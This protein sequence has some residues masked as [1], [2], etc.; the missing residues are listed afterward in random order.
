RN[1]LAS[2]VGDD[3][4]ERR[5]DAYLETGPDVVSFLHENT[6]LRLR[7]VREY[8][9]YH[10]EAA[11]G[12]ARGR[13]IE[14]LPLDGRT[15]GPELTNLEPPYSDPPLGVPMNQVDYRWI[16]LLARHPKG[17]WQ[18]AKLGTRWLAGLAQGKRVQLSM[19][20]ALAGGL[21]AGLRRA[22]V[23][24]W[25]R[26]PIVDL[27]TENGRVT[28]VTVER[29]GKQQTIRAR[30]GVILGTGGYE[31]NAAMREQY[32][33]QPIGT[34]WT[35]GAKANTGD[36][37]N[38]GM[39]AGGTVDLMDDSWWGPTIPLTGGPWFALAERSR[40]GCIM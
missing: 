40:P 13:S 6:P 30:R 28:G 31:H 17:T 23:P 14:P 35:V 1:Y 15:L 8:S 7:W 11:G 20:Q 36:G 32:Q 25:L 38:A 22:G 5:R 9:D 24:V 2:I 10:P 21:R 19:G 26:T 27:V 37:I 18:L 34:E 16:S 4:S 12:R 39:R 3:V 33:R 29:D